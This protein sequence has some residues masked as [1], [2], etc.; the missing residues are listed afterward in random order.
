MNIAIG[1]DHAGFELKKRLCAIVEEE[2]HKVFDVGCH[3]LDSVD[4]PAQG[5]RVA[6]LVAAGDCDRGILICGTGIGMSIVA[7]RI[8]GVRAALCHELLTARLSREHNDANLL[9]LG[10]RVIGPALA[11]EMVRIWLETPFSGG[12][13]TCRLQQIDQAPTAN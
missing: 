10:G 11:E 8:P 9:C 7:N 5:R 3:S 13:H 2:G 1:S 6:H 4:Y 12:R